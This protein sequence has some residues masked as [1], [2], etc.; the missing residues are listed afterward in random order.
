MPRMQLLGHEVVAWLVFKK[1]SNCLPKSLCHFTCQPAKFEWSFL[2]ILISIWCCHYC[3]ILATLMGVWYPAVTLMC[4]SRTVADAGHVFMCLFAITFWV[5]C[6]S[7]S[8][9]HFLIG[10]LFLT[11][12]FWE[13]LPYCRYL[14]LASKYLAYKYVLQF[15]RIYHNKSFTFLRSSIYPFFPFI[16]CAFVI[17]SKNFLFAPI[18]RRFSPVIFSKHFILHL[19]SWSILHWFLYNMRGLGWD[20]FIFFLFCPRVPNFSSTT[21]GKG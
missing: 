20:S 8:F 21:C 1:P 5:K 19:N 15:N 12:G 17:E 7:L 14:V 9:T 6:L 11:F 13:F 16:S 4:I 10:Y 18:F 2:L 3:F